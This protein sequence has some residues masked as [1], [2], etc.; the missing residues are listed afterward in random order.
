VADGAEA[1]TLYCIMDFCPE[2]AALC[3]MI[4]GK[5]RVSGGRFHRR[6]TFIVSCGGTEGR[7]I[8]QSLKLV[9]QRRAVSGTRGTQSR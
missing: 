8:Q 1:V 9:D 6:D 2:S 4:R 7:L 5:R 3:H